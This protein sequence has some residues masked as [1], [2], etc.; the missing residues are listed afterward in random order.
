[1]LISCAAS[2]GASVRVNMAP[3]RKLG[4]AA[5]APKVASKAKAKAVAPP[6]ADDAAG[7]ADVTIE[8]WCDLGAPLPG[9][10][11]CRCAHEDDNPEAHK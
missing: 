7:T 3:R 6:P 4:V 11:S 2:V 5:P 9:E 1:M 10:P 8:H